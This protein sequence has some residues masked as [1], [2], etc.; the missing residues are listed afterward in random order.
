V[1][2]FMDWMMTN[3]APTKYWA[4]R[5]TPA[6]FSQGGPN[7]VAVE[8]MVEIA[9]TLKA[10]PWF[11]MPFSADADY[12]RQFAIYV[13]DHLARDR[14]VY[15]EYSNEV[16][17]TAFRQG[18]DAVRLGQQRY[19]GMEASQAG[20]FYYAD[21]VR[22]VMDIWSDVFRGQESRLV[23][24][25]ASQ[26]VNPRRGDLAL[27]H[28]D[29]WKSVDAF[30]T[31]GYFGEGYKGSATPGPER[32]TAIINAVPNTVER[33]IAYSKAGK[34]VADRYGLRHV[35]YE[36]GLSM[37]TSRTDPS[38]A[39]DTYAAGADPRLKAAY[40]QFLSRYRDE[41]G[42]LLLLYNSVAP[43]GGNYTWWG[44]K[45]YTGQPLAEAPKMGAAVEA[46]KANNRR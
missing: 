7:G 42:D 28:A 18:K 4:T 11:N 26:Q 36:G 45:A 25:F 19:P 1:L 14:K 2:R 21:Q 37:N 41:V 30:S 35:A 29:T 39:A 16:W 38:L 31:A 17:N 40:L 27:A 46:A 8:Y 10:D 43:P 24:V 5:A 34:A 13:R 3:N 15:V 23:R 44:H 22:M 6:S 9:N 20:D 32:V 12:Y 33:Y